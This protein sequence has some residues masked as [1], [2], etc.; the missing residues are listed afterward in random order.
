MPVD[1][2]EKG[3][4]KAVENHLLGHGY[5]KGD[6]ARFDRQLALDPKTLVGFLRDT[7]PKEWAK[8]A[9]FYGGEVEAKVVRT[10]AQ[11]LDQRGMLD[12]LRNGVT[13]R[14][15]K[16]RLAHFKPATGLNPET[17]DLYAKNVLTITR[18]VHYSEKDPTLSIDVLLSLNGL[19]VAT[20][21]L[22]NPFTG[23]TVEDAKAQYKR[24]RD[25]REPLFSFKRRALVHLAVDPDDVL[26][27]TR[28]A[29]KDTA[30]LP[31]NKGRHGGKGNPDNPAS[32]WKTAYL[33]EEVWE[34]D[35]WLDILARFLHLE[36]REEIKEGQKV[37]KEAI[38]FPRYHQLDAVRRLIATAKAS[39]PGRNYLIQHSAGS[40]KSNTIAWLAHRLSNLHDAA[41]KLVYDGIIVVTD[42]RVLDKQLQDTIYQFE[43]KQGVVQRIDEDSA[44]LAGALAAG[45]RIIITTLQKFSFVLEKIKDLP[46]RTYA[47]IV[48]EA[49]SS[50]TGEAAG[51]LRRVLAAQSLEEAEKEEGGED[52]TENAAEEEILK[53]LKARG[54]QKNLSYFAFT[55]TPK[56]KTLELFG[57]DGPD[58]RPRPFHLYSMRQAI[59]E[60]FILDVLRNYVTYKAYY[61]L[62]KVIEDDPEFDRS[63]ATQAVARFV[64]LHPHN[65]AQ[66]TEVMVEHFRNFTRK[67][68]GGR[69]KA[70]VVTRSRLHAVRYKKALD[71]YLKEKGY[72]DLKVLV[73]F[74]GTVHDEGVDYTEPAMNGFGEKE[75]PRRFDTDQYQLLIV[76]EKYQTGFDQPLLHTMYVDRKLQGLQAVQTL[77]RLNRTCPGKEDTFVLDFENEAEEI[78]EAFRPYYEQTEVVE[79]V[80]PNLLYTLKHRLDDFQVYWRQDVEDFAKVFFKPVAQQ[81]DQDKGLLHKHIDPAVGRFRAEP[82]ERRAD[83][84]H[85][86][87]TFLRLYAFLSQLVDFQD[88]DLE[89]LYAFGR[90]LITKLGEGDEGGRL[91]IDDEVK[92]S[93][94]RLE[95]TFE[96][97]T[98][99]A[100]GESAPV[101]GPT[102]VGTGRPKEEDLACLSEI[103]EVLNDRFGTDFKAEDQ[104]LFDQVV[105]DLKSDEQLAD[106]A[107]SNSID[108][109]KYAFDPKA[110]AAFLGRMDRNQDISSQFMANEDL[111][112]VALE[113][114]MKQVFSHFQ[115]TPPPAAMLD[116]GAEPSP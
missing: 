29:G 99:L 2:T 12:C 101:S 4:E 15:V 27:T 42:R 33:W 36:V 98:S 30:F 7:Q 114:M 87:G 80:D 97:S 89:K 115:G 3:F 78:Q 76:A 53:A 58:G 9:G 96:G 45:A 85:Q 22:K 56:H 51:H 65:L 23:Q 68:I 44:Q 40:G 72:N 6:P 11:N 105:G 20:A 43:H 32:G 47:L 75:L 110:M 14:G 77:S 63:K 95:K 116:R 70:M 1:H 83:F 104:L 81:R 67:K 92:L 60:G 107:R 66:K 13:D 108:Q 28:L 90:L 38:V 26:M 10:V 54:P 21:E 106:Q 100:A 113:W 111:R 109:F 94:F 35:S 16:L 19:P 93:Y 46:K 55:A 5:S 49:H 17:L 37:R 82:E 102:E 41:D 112:R 61:K 91:L 52:V 24:D 74:S 64:G 31:F 8:L 34:R 88:P 71:K 25:A 86:L 48:D 69:A 59:E 39:G 62:A 79:R 57:E 84:R 50:Q 18:Q 73:A 103:V